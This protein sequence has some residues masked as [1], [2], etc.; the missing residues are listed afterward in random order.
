MLS[1]SS[2]EGTGGGYVLEGTAFYDY[3]APC[4]YGLVAFKRLYNGGTHEHFYTAS[5]GEHDSLV[6]SGWIDEGDVGCIAPSDVGCGDVHLH[7]L[8]QSKHLFTT[9]DAEASSVVASGWTDEGI[10]GWVW[11]GP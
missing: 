7:R 9:S 2:S 10:A 11:N 1:L 8:V 3:P 5:V 6:A 4:A